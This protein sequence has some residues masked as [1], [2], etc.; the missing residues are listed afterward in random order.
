ME[1]ASARS[2]TPTRSRPIRHDSI[3]P[4]SEDVAQASLPAASRS[5]LASCFETG[6]KGAPRTRTLEACATFPALRF[7]P[8]VKS[9]HELQFLTMRHEAALERLAEKPPDRFAAALAV[10]QRPVVHVHSHKLVG[11]IAAHV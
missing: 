7:P 10:V 3:A 9:S 4:G 11:E 5:I 6:S 1:A 2:T 8:Y